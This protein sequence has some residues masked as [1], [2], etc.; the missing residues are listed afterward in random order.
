LNVVARIARGKIEDLKTLVD[1]VDNY[2]AVFFPGGYGAAKN[3]SNFAFS[4]GE[5]T[6]NKEVEEYVKILL[7][8]PVLTL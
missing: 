8:L 7:F 1:N 4:E 6:V 2:D 5:Y 3:L